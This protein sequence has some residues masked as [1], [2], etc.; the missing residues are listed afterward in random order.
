MNL[1]TY[2]DSL[3]RGGIVKFAEQIKVS[4]VYLSQ[5]A[6]NQDN[7]EASPSLCVVIE[8]ESGGAVTRQ[9]LRGDWQAIWPELIADAGA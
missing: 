4:P 7:R 9:E 1:R 8:R 3:P 6:A 2:L 5:L